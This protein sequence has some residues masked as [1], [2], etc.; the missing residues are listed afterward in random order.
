MLHGTMNHR[1]RIS[2]TMEL[3]EL[4]GL[5]PRFIRRYP[6]QFS[7]GQRQRIAVARALASDAALIICDEPT[8]AL[9]VSIQAQVIT[10]LENLQRELALTY[11]F[12]SH[13]LAV[14]RYIANRIAVMYNGRIVETAP[15][16]ELFRKPRDAYTRTLIDAVLVP[17]RQ[18]GRERESSVAESGHPELQDLAGQG[19]STKLPH[20]ASA[21]GSDRLAI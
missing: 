7:G 13:D 1:A 6:H 4:V 16:S 20:S 11:L 5:D 8:S 3:L 18:G 14:V 19:S 2:K 15:T 9:D 17:D 21:P 10:L 12:I